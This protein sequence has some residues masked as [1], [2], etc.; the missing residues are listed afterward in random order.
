[1]SITISA[2]PEII[3][4]ID[5]KTNANLREDQTPLVKMAPALGFE[6]RRGGFGDRPTQPTLTGSLYGNF[7]L[8]TS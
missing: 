4:L 3:T 2:A 6:P 7:D 1:V 8:N 5:G